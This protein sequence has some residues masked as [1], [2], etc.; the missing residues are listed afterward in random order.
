MKVS[1]GNKMLIRRP[2]D[3][4]TY[5]DVVDLK[6]II[7]HKDNWQ[8]FE[9][10]MNIRLPSDRKGNAKNVSWFDTLKTTFEKSWLIR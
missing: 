1:K 2:T 7:E 8:H 10:T 6:K 4:I 3:A 5:L 9:P